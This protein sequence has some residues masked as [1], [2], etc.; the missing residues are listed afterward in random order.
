MAFPS[1]LQGHRDLMEK[2][3]QALGESLTCRILGSAREPLLPSTK[4]KETSVSCEGDP[5]SKPS[6]RLAHLGSSASL[7]TV[8]TPSGWIRA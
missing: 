2:V 4:R 1:W 3:N 7:C 5:G 8:A 6:S